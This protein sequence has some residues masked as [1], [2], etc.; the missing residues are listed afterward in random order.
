MI[1]L[2]KNEH[3]YEAG[4]KTILLVDDDKFTRQVYKTYFEKNGFIVKEA[5]DGKEAIAVVERES[6]INVVLLDLLMPT[7]DGFIFLKHFS[8]NNTAS[9]VKV[10]LITSLDKEDYRNNVSVM[11]I[12]TS[13]VHGFFNKP[14]DLKEVCALV[15]KLDYT[16]V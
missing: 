6:A 8:N 1:Q 15:K 7:H 9:D 4:S 10:I 14:V 2:D 3:T 11:H 5:V 16:T 13:R 12:D